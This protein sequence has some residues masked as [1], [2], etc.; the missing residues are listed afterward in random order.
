MPP[1]VEALRSRLIARGT[2]T[3][4]TLET[5]LKNAPDELSEIYKRPEFFTMRIVNE[6]LA[7]SR[8]TFELLIESV[9]AREGLRQPKITGFFGTYRSTIIGFGLL[10][11]FVAAHEILRRR[12]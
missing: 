5:R 9:Y 8:S 10:V 7:L 11:G 2:E 4:K 6:D 1:N 3:E 12:K